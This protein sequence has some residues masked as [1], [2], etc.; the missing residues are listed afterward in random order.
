MLKHNIMNSYLCHQL[1]SF[2][3]IVFFVSLLHKLVNL[4]ALKVSIN[5]EMSAKRNLK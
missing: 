4:V 5:E 2:L 3:H 1:N